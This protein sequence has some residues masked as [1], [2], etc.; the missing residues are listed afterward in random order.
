MHFYKDLDFV[1][2][3]TLALI[4]T[5]LSTGFMCIYIYIYILTIYIY[6]DGCVYKFEVKINIYIYI[7]QPNVHLNTFPH[8]RPKY[9]ILTHTHADS[10]PNH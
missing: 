2:I 10:E 6:I 1:Y 4:H 9:N 3:Y 8:E 7:H 5:L